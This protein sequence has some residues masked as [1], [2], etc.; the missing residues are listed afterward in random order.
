MT[1]KKHTDTQSGIDSETQQL[2]TIHYPSLH[3]V[4]QHT[5]LSELHRIYGKRDK[6]SSLYA[7]YI[8]VL[9]YS[10]QQQHGDV[11]EEKCHDDKENDSTNA[12]LKYRDE[13]CKQHN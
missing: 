13:L 5:R 7:A 9:R 1:V 2:H 12:L 8:T 3:D 6:I 10:D 4:I 11:N